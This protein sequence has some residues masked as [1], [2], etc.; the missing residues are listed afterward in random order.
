VLV[1]ADGRVK[2]S[3]LWLDRLHLLSPAQEEGRDLLTRLAKL[4]PKL[5]EKL[6]RLE[7]DGKTEFNGQLHLAGSFPDVSGTLEFTEISIGSYRWD[8]IVAPFRLDRNALAIEDG[9]LE[10][11]RT[12][13]G[14]NL[15][16]RLEPETQLARIDLD[17]AALEYRRL[18]RILYFLDLSLGE[19]KP[20]GYLN[21]WLHGKLHLEGFDGPA[22]GGNWDLS[23]RPV[24]VWAEEVGALSL[25]GSL[26]DHRLALDQ[27]R[28]RGPDLLVE[29]SGG[30]D[31]A[32]GQVR[33]QA[34]I[35]ELR[36]ERLPARLQAGLNGALHG[37]ATIS[38]PLQDPLIE[39]EVRSD[40][41]L[42]YGEPFGDL[43][44]NGHREQ[45]RLNF[46]LRTAYNQNL[47]NAFGSLDWSSKPVLEAT[48]LLAN[49]QVQPFLRQFKLPLADEI[50][51]VATGAIV[52]TYPFGAPERL[53]LSARLDQARVE[54]R[55][56]NIQNQAPLFLGLDKGR[57][58]LQNTGLKLNGDQLSL[59]GELDVMPFKRIQANLNGQLSAE[60]I[61]P[62]VPE[63]L[64]AGKF[65]VQCAVRGE[66][67]NPFFSG[68][69]G[70]KDVSVKVRGSDLVF[71]KI[72]GT[73]ELTSQTI[74]AERITLES[75]YGPMT[76]GGDC[77]LDGF[78][79]SRW[80][81]NL[82]ADRLHMPI[83]K[84]FLTQAAANLKLVGNPKT[85]ILSGNIWLE[86]STL[87]Q[88]LD[89]I[90]FVTLLANFEFTSGEGAPLA[91][92][93]PVALNLNIKGDQSI[94]IETDSIDAI[95]SL[96]LQVMG[97]LGQPLVRGSLLVNS[98]EFKFRANRFTLDRGLLQFL[99]PGVL[100]PHLNL[101]ASADIKDYRVSILLEGPLSR[102]R[103][104]FTSV[105]SL[106]S[107]DVVQLIATGYLPGGTGYRSTGQDRP[108]NSN[109]LLSQMLSAT[110]QE[111]FTK[112]IG[113]DTFSV[114]TYSTDG[115]SSQDAQVSV[116]KQISKDLYV[117][118][119]RSVTDS[120]QDQF[121][122]EYRLS[123][124]LTVV[125]AEDR[126]GY[127]GIDFR[128]RKRF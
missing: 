55:H 66:A 40:K 31:L 14:L 90:E 116:G 42:F 70:L 110:I 46:T 34:D 22:P 79:P 85:S 23:I 92:P 57:L 73:L 37:R 86:R 99:N 87:A 83:P 7:M 58:V 76:L 113:V 126:D 6:G 28:L 43:W 125:A 119:S 109:I 11:G 89:L 117:V 82:D 77:L 59:R 74:R 53:E 84:G 123:P 12:R 124:K 120:G 91:T 26:A 56:L 45:S 61:Q 44:L 64:P 29:A 103:T 4:S 88:K 98:G 17:V 115:S 2:G 95:G 68:R 65:D 25:K 35:R 100:D 121:F 122:I 47:Y 27:V 97:S 107:V 71:K 62:F 16:L 20:S 67:A 60:L 111:R 63:I 3:E 32:G 8:R 51:G 21:G 10:D 48:L 13:V 39:L 75:L 96:D 38:G 54:F 80:N 30:L 127:Y 33:L 50:R 78:T 36:L 101:Q 72:N 52:C 49:I 69:I 18:E 104:R 81:L 106:P 108:I 102:L 94:I 112:S 118:Y 24:E 105:P 41:V 128:F 19:T 5:T 15:D 93:V 9:R 1:E 114:D